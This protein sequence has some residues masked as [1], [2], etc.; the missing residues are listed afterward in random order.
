MPR[1]KEP[2]LKQK[3]FVEA[4]KRTGNGSLSARMAGYKPKYSAQMAAQ[5]LTT[6]AIENLIEQGSR[7]GLDTL[8][9]VSMNSNVDIARVRA[10]E[11]LIERQHGKAR[12][13]RDDVRTLPNITLVFNRVDN[14]DSTPIEAQIINQTTDVI[15]HTG[16]SQG[17]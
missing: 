12:N 4:Y 2:S 11:V 6:K 5:L 15:P 3:R 14:N 1:L 17:K 16:P 7:I 9:D 10:A 13:N 8:I